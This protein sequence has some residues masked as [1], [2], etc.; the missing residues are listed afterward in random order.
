[1]NIITNCVASD[2]SHHFCCRRVVQ[3]LYQFNGDIQGVMY[4]LLKEYN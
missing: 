3:L 2:H 1:M 4:L